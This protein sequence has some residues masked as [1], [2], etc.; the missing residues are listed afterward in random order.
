MQKSGSFR[1]DLYYRLCTHRVRIPRLRDRLDDLPLL[2]DHFMHEASQQM[3]KKTPKAPKELIT[4]LS[5]YNFPGNVRELRAMVFDA[6]S[7]HSSMMLSMESFKEHIYGT[8]DGEM[9]LTLGKETSDSGNLSFGP[10]LPTLEEA[11]QLLIEEALRRTGGNKSLAA[12]M[13]G[14][15]RQALILRERRKNS[16]TL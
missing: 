14:V 3:G 8:S 15:T 2:L 5:N 1:K 9:D 11:K 6:V 4:L 13:L 16:D 7:Q 12:T 10:K